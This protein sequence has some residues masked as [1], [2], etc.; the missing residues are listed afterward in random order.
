MFVEQVTGRSGDAMQRMSRSGL[1]PFCF[2]EAHSSAG[3]D[4][5]VFYQRQAD[6]LLRTPVVPDPRYLDIYE[7]QFFARALSNRQGKSLPWDLPETHR[8]FED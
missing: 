2:D 8:G 7:Q 4:S 3:D 1:Q 5:L 6:D